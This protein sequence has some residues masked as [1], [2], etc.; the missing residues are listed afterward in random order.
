MTL[1]PKLFLAVIIFAGLGI[2]AG[3]G[4]LAAEGMALPQGLVSL[5]YKEALTAASQG[6]KSILIYFWAD[7]CPSCRNFNSATLPNPAVKKTINDSFALIS[8]NTAE[9]LDGLAKDFQIR[10]IPAFVFL[11]SE[12]EPIT[13]L[14]GAVDAEIFVLVLNYISSGSYA[15]MEFEDFA[16]LSAP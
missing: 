4:S 7:W 9:D 8:V 10:A 5:R 11:D 1:R 3:A 13:M 6:Q 2:L 14:P 15:S 16:K 12:G